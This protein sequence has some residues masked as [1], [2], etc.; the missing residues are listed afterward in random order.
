[1]ANPAAGVCGGLIAL[2]G[3]TDTTEALKNVYVPTLVMVGE[4]DTLTP[5]AAAQ[6]LS[7]RIAT[8]T[9]Q[10]IPHAGHMSNM[11]NPAAFNEH[12]LAF[13]RTLPA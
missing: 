7:Q 10:T 8:A 13:L 1:M 6:S 11:E 4:H 2:A 12:L 3:R 9:L 5:P